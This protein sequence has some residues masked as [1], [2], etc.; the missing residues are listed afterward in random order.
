MKH[1]QTKG[2]FLAILAAVL[3]ALSS[4]FSKLLLEKI[5][6]TMMAAFLYLGAGAGMFLVGLTQKKTKEQPLTRKEL[7]YTIGMV[8]LDIAAP[9]FLMI[10]LTMTTAAN[11]ALLNNFEIVATSIIALV[12]F[13]EVI[14]KR[15]WLAIGLVTLSSLILSFQ[16]MSSFS[17]SA[18]SLLVLAA[19]ICW[20]LENNCTRMLSV[21]NPLQIVVIKGFGSGFGSLAIALFLGEKVADVWYMIGALLLGFVAY[22]LSIFCYIYAQRDLGAAKTSTYYAVA[23]FI[24][25]ALSLL[26]FREMPSVTFM[27]ALVIM[28]VGTYFASTEGK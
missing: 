26:I 11:A 15:L 3:Y 25:T 9:I 14:S 7:P 24:G 12:I 5:S 1:K 18:G 6:P 20:G 22:G 4:P 2:V 23:P 8:V 10:G 21:K 13:K 19:C 16:D 27:I 28:M 17:F